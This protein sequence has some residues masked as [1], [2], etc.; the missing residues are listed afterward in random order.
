VATKR[1]VG[2]RGRTELSPGSERVVI[3]EVYMLISKH[4]SHRCERLLGLIVRLAIS[5]QTAA[6]SQEHLHPVAVGCRYTRLESV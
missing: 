3:C 5:G 6:H 1:S 2:K 4:R